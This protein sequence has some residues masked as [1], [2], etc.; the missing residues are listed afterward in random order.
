MESPPPAKKRVKEDIL[1]RA[2]DYVRE[3]CKKSEGEDKLRLDFALV[4]MNQL[5]AEA[6]D[7]A[8]AKRKLMRAS[9]RIGRSLSKITTRAYNLTKE[10]AIDYLIELRAIIDKYCELKLY[11]VARPLSDLCENINER[12]N[13]DGD[14]TRP[15]RFNKVEFEDVLERLLDRANFMLVHRYHQLP[16]LF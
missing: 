3:V 1:V 4:L 12:F 13:I 11:S 7:D 16:F 14:W 9:N 5:D 10:N 2:M 6:Y 15:Y 8:K